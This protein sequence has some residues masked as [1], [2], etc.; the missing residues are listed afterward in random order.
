M[1]GI[2]QKYLIY[3]LYILLALSGATAGYYYLRCGQLANKAA[4]L[5]HELTMAQD[6]NAESTKTIA[7]LTSERAASEKTCEAR[8]RGYDATLAELQRIDGLKGGTDGHGDGNHID[9]GG[10]PLLDALNGMYPAGGQDGVC[11][12]DNPRDS[13]GSGVLPGSVRYCFCGEQDVKN[14]LKN[15]ALARGDRENLAA[16]L[17]G[18]R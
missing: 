16:I 8:L 5:T 15:N 1:F 14:L 9:S 12:T 7:A 11:Q 2:I 10:D 17:E 3:A 4:A 13:G 18:L 6:A